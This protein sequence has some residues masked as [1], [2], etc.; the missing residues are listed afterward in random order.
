MSV[1]DV[2]LNGNVLWIRQSAFRGVLQ[3]PKTAKAIRCVS[4]SEKL[5]A[6]L[7][8][9]LQTDYRE[10]H[11]HL[12]FATR[13][14]HALDNGAIVT[15]K[16]R[17][18]TNRLGFPVAGLHAFRHANATELD[19]MGAPIAVRMERLGHADFDTTLT[20]THALSEDSRRVANEFG[21]L[22]SGESSEVLCPSLPLA[23]PPASSN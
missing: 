16:L 18:I 20:Y 9:Y 2:D 5:S 19:R 10:N 8:L 1:P 15:F 3:T 21:H 13:G 17:P 14:G 11:D 23:L 6:H 12:L 4:I 22:L 7:K